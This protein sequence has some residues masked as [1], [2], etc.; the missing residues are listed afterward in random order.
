VTVVGTSDAS[1]S[2]LLSAVLKPAYPQYHL[3]YVSL[4]TGAA[5]N[6]A[7]AGSASAL[8]VHAASLENQFVAGGYSDE[9]YGRATFYGDYVLLGPASDPAGV[10]ANAPHGIVT[11]FERIPA[12]PAHA[13][14]PDPSGHLR[15]DVGQPWPSSLS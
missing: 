5:I 3:N 4:G 2:N 15:Q 1:D 13:V 10:L 9:P 8:L 7:K 6:Y 14:G 11:A 12:A